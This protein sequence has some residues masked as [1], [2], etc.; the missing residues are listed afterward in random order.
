MQ[1]QRLGTHR[2]ATDCLPKDPL[3]VDVGAG[4]CNFSFW[5][6]QTFGGRAAAL[7]PSPT[8]VVTP[9]PEDVIGKV[10][11]EKKAIWTH[12]KGVTFNSYWQ[13]PESG[14]VIPR[15]E[16]GKVTEHD[17]ETE[18]L[19]CLVDRLG[20][21]DVLKMDM[22][23]GEWDV[24]PATPDHVFERIGQFTIELHTDFPKADSEALV[25]RMRKL[26]FVVDLSDSPTPHRPEMYGYRCGLKPVVLDLDDFSEEIMYDHLWDLLFRVRS[27]YPRFKATMFTIPLQCSRQW[28]EMVHESYDWIEMHHHGTNHDDRDRFMRRRVEVL[29]EVADGLLYKGFKAPWW[30]MTQ[31]VADQL[32]AAGIDVMSVNRDF[33][34]RG[35]ATYQYDAGEEIR[36]GTLYEH[37]RFHSW[38]GHVQSQPHGAPPNGLPNIFD[39]LVTQFPRGTEFLTVGELGGRGWLI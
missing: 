31:E 11:L 35:S 38:H 10:E 37:E 39:M 27:V 26:G 9:W 5:F 21:V 18:T 7:E 12:A 2:V 33:P 24:L 15:K 4:D 3:A 28:L 23:G 17:V 34:C 1:F 20:W 32:T 29:P 16:R 30:R 14:S 13:H 22:E 25:G 8:W 19:A 36:R 6:V